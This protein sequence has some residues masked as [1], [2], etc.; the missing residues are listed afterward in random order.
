LDEV[1]GIGTRAAVIL[2]SVAH[3]GALGV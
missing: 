3:A 2:W 1:D